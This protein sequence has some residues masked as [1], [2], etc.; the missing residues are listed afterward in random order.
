MDDNLVGYLLKAL[1]PDAQRDVEAYLQTNP[2][3]Q[4]R[5]DTLRQ[6]LEPLAADRA[7]IEP[8]SGL[9]IRTLGRV[10]E[11]CCRELPRAPVDNVPEAPVASRPFWRRADVLVA[12]TLFLTTL[13]VGIS[14]VSRAH[15]QRYITECQNNL[16][17]FYGALKSYADHHDNRLPNVAAV[18]PPRNVAGLV[19]PI[20]MDA[21]T[22]PRDVN[23]GC[24][25]NSKPR[26]CP[27]TLERLQA[28]DA[29]T[30][31]QHAQDLICCYAYSLGYQDQNGYHGPRFDPDQPNH[32]LPIMADS[33]PANPI[34]G[35]SLNHGRSGQNVLFLDGSV[36]FCPTRTVGMHG[37]DIYLNRAG[38]QAAGLGFTDTVLGSSASCP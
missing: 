35:N 25:G 9:V 26:T 5:L 15:A 3:A 2:D 6:A 38:R 4:L 31:K 8:P 10:A 11:Y 12:A 16:R 34:D 36:R 7:E 20:L 22:L 29:E 18:E 33:P 24:P 32:L 19:V 17:V 21:G 1:D 37:D 30:F 23:V 27:L 13:G 28:L 14:W